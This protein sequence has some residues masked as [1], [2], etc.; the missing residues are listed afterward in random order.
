MNIGNAVIAWDSAVQSL[1]VPMADDTVTDG[2]EIKDN[3]VDFITPFVLIVIAVLALKFLM[4]RRMTNFFQFI[5]IGI[6]V[7]MLLKNP[8]IIQGFGERAGEFFSSSGKTLSQELPISEKAEH[9]P[10]V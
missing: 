4:Q 9:L 7:F 1:S 10:V 2:F 5:G 6:L 8:Q 3:L